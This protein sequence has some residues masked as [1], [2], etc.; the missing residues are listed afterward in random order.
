MHRLSFALAFL[1]AAIIAFQLALI[2]I[3]SV[4]QWYHLAYMVISLAL[5]GFGAAGSFLSLFQ[6]YLVSRAG[7][8]IPV[9]MI[10]TALS[11]CLVADVAQM[12]FVRFDS[13]LLFAEYA[14]IGK[15]I[16]TYL[17]FFIPFFL[18]ALA[19]GLAF[20]KNVDT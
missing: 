17:L 15:L 12:P 11:M 9:L 19:I 1:S 6:T 8:L 7:L 3:L 20:V 10:A 16:L 2:Q 5:R 13:Y 4:S 18:G 14:H